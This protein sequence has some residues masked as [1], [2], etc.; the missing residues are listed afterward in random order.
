MGSGRE[1]PN[2]LLVRYGPSKGRA[3]TAVA[4]TAA[5]KEMKRIVNAVV[6]RFEIGS[7]RRSTKQQ[8]G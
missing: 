7:T 5:A 6:Q 1:L 8:P 3:E 4:K 2:G